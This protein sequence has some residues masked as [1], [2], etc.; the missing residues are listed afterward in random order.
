MTIND[1][2][3]KMFYANTP[4]NKSSEQV[5]G[6][7]VT[8]LDDEYYRIE[9]YDALDPFFITL[10]SSSNHWLFISTTGG[11]TAGR[12]DANHALFPYYT[13]DRITENSENTGSKTI[14]L[15][16][17]GDRKNVWMPF[18]T[19]YQGVYEIKR[20]IYKNRPGTSIIFEEIN[21]TLQLTYRYAWRTTERFGFVKT[22]YLVN[23][24]DNACSVNIVDGLQNLLPAQVSTDVQNTFS[25]LLDAYKMSELHPPT[26]LGLFSLSSRLTDLAEPSEALRTN[27]VWQV[28][29]DDVTHLLSS[30]QLDAF[31]NGEA[32]EPEMAIRGKR[33]AYFI[34]KQ[35]SLEPHR[36]YK[37]HFVA[38]VEQDSTQAAALVNMLSTEK[39]NLFQ[40]V[41]DDIRANQEQLEEILA[42]ADARQLSSDKLSTT[43][44]LANV[45]FNV[46]RGG[47]FANNHT[48]DTR[49]LRDY[50]AVHKSSLLETHSAFFDSLPE[51]ITV[52]ELRNKVNADDTPDLVRLCYSYLP[53]TFS[54]RHGDPS[55]PWN[56]FQI[57]LKHADGSERL[58]YQG[59]WR[60]VFQNWEALSYSYPEFIDGMISV[61]LNATTVDGYNPYRIFRDG[62]DWE[63]PEPGNAWANIGYWSDHQIIYLEKLLEVC[64]R[65]YPGKL[66]T[67]LTQRIFSYADVPYIIKAY[68]E[69]IKNPYNTIDFD[70]D[71]EEL[72][73]A[74][75]EQY[76]A[77]GKLV[78]DSDGY[79][80]HG[81]LGEKLLILLL[82]KLVNFVPEG[83][84][85]MN[86]QRPEWNDANNALVGKGLSVVTLS[87]MHRYIDFFLTL[88]ESSDAQDITLS[89]DI[90]TLF[91][92]IH[93]IL[94]DY[95]PLLGGAINDTQ[96]REIMDKLGVAGTAYRQKYYAQGI[97]SETTDVAVADIVGFLQ[98]AQQH[99]EHTLRANKRDDNLY[100]AYNT[101]SFSQNGA[102]VNYLSEMLEGQVAILSSGLLSPDEALELF[103]SLR[104]SALYR[105]D[106]HSYILYPNRDVAGFLERNLVPADA[107]ESSQLVA[108]LLKNND[109]R[110]I[111]K[112]INGVYH[113]HGDIRNAGDVEKVLAK[114]ASDAKYAD[115]VE[116]ETDTILNTFE[117]VFNHVAFTGRSG[118]FFAY[119]GL[120]SIYWHMVSKLLLAMQENVLAAAQSD[121]SA[122]T[123]QAL[124]NAYEDIRAGIG[125][126][127]TPDVYGAFPAD[128]YSHTPANQG[129]KQPGMTGM[130]KEEILT[131]FVELGIVIDRGMI[132]I[133]TTVFRA[134]ELLETEAIFEYIDI[135]GEDQQI[136]VPVNALAFTLCQTPVV[137]GQ[138]SE[139]KFEVLFTDGNVETFDNAQLSNTISQHVFARDGV[140][141]RINVYV[142]GA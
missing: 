22:A 41:E 74:R 81:S 133:D 104:H 42:S 61:F 31:A 71:K 17:D 129:A 46:M 110:L 125:F 58:D 16:D 10:V 50:I 15:L 138:A 128:P 113:F 8:I 95:Q 6:E 48:I 100:H 88:L 13:D 101:L 73:E 78:H 79:V 72:V 99:V 26:G 141:Q 19:R 106:Q 117:Q 140:V 63:V 118:T 51:T 21:H 103:K 7:F 122:E 94:I 49:D 97:S 115:L 111:S 43:H 136:A 116:A 114:I 124:K 98:V 45:L 23:D 55:R 80:Y 1:T 47:I 44:H 14:I 5:S 62:I 27:T 3:N 64:E 32:V 123:L 82:A 126:N 66:Q 68:Q 33:G 69:M 107:I 93:Q 85:W 9:N 91:E 54:R 39:A 76:G 59:N 84:I 75:T 109:R 77:D 131:R 20:N 52:A 134:Q 24:R 96:R 30:M 119:E 70:W 142:S 18:S 2:Q 40:Q 34:Q 28:G 127:K 87:Y 139:D 83:G 89:E 11:L 4:H 92:A 60:D 121:T 67:L 120:G 65:F 130:V 56:R 86:T 38:E 135:N 37:W 25:N 132:S 57:N 90:N 108:T 102:R 35:M 105:P 112:D 53:L 12:I 137:L 36:E 29:L